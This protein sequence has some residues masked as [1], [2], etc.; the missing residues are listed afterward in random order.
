MGLSISMNSIL[1]FSAEDLKLHKSPFKKP[2]E[3]SSSVLDPVSIQI[4]TAEPIFSPNFYPFFSFSSLQL[5]KISCQ[6]LTLESIQAFSSSVSSHGHFGRCSPLHT[7]ILGSLFGSL[8]P[9]EQ[10]FGREVA[11]RS[12]ALRTG[13]VL[14]QFLCNRKREKSPLFGSLS[15]SLSPGCIKKYCHFQ[16]IIWGDKNCN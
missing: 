5:L 4:I 11:C 3:L 13:F 7:D 15:P 16:G 2:R 8:S 9:A 10:L 6:Q 12:G 1:L 14:Y